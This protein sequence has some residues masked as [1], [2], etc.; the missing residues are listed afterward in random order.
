MLPSYAAAIFA[1][2]DKMLPPSSLF[3]MLMMLFEDTHAAVIAATPIIADYAHVC[4]LL[5][6]FSRLF[7]V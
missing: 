3:A 4:C 1:E 6:T 7:E 5:F 2:A